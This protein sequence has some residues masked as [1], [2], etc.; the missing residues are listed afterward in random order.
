M[1][2][3]NGT[4]ITKFLNRYILFIVPNFCIHLVI[5]IT[6]NILPRETPCVKVNEKVAY[7]LE[8]IPSRKFMA[9]MRVKR[10]IPCG[11]SKVF[12]CLVRNVLF[13]LGVYV[14]LCEAHINYVEGRR[15]LLNP[16][17]KVVRLDVSMYELFLVHVL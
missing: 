16:H 15:V 5:F 11:T 17:Q 6:L 9:V 8:V 10:S 14:S 7:S 13:R 1:L 12:V 2:K 4:I 3:L